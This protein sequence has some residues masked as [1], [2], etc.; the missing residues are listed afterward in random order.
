MQR[1]DEPRSTVRPAATSACPATCPPKTRRRSPSGSGRGRGSPRAPRGRGSRSARRRRGM[2]PCG[3][4]SL[5]HPRSLAPVRRR[6]EIG[7]MRAAV[8]REAQ[9]VVDTVPDPEP[10]PGEMLV[11]TLACGI[12]GSDLH[13]LA[14][15][16]QDGGSRARGGAPLRWTS[17]RRRHGTRVLR[18]G[19]RLRAGYARACQAGRR[20]C[21]CRSSSAG[22]H[23]GHRLLERRARRLRRAHGPPAALALP[24]P[25]GLPTEH[26]A[27]TEPMAVGLHAVEKARL[28]PHDA[29][30]VFGCGP[31]GLAVIAALKLKGVEPIVAADFSPM[32]RA[33]AE[34][35]GA[36]AVVDPARP[37]DR[38]TP[39]AR[40]PT[41]GR[42]CSS[43]ASAC[44][45]AA[46][47]HAPGAA[48]R[49]HRGGRCLHGRRYHPADPRHQ[50]GAEPPVR[51]RLH[52]V[53]VR[54][55]R[56]AAIAD[57]HIDV[58]PLITGAVGVDGVAQAFR[59]LGR[60][61][62]TRRSLVEPW[63]S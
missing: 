28:E 62:S 24:V 36:H 27:L 43:S 54:R 23:P 60:R 37:P 18:R 50:Q 10:G 26:A 5:L 40:S 25:N 61:S 58:A 30:L 9:L 59:D 6:G 2:R 52:A 11:R 42:R 45:C 8:M 16:A 41:S 39:T 22:R 48:R 46:R 15:R 32:R 57:G 44:R 12:C 34:R 51:A 55:T 38:S 63:R 13:A 14:P 33:L 49:A 35:M 56:S 7:D 21:R 3:T 17:A 20:V 19:A 4:A 31:V 29:A 1:V 53:G 47:D